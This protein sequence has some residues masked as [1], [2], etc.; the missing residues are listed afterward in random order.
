MKWP[1]CGP[2]RTLRADGVEDRLGR[3]AL[4]PHELT[5]GD[6]AHPP[7]EK[8]EGANGP[9]PSLRLRRTL[10][11]L[12]N[13]HQITDLLCRQAR[14]FAREASQQNTCA[15]TQNRGGRFIK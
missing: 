4:I 9:F 6:P 10:F 11:A 7:T 13:G 15:C 14:L 2:E 8:V 5:S 3:K 1:V 12:V